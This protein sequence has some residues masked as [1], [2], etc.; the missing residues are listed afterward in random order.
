MRIRA[1]LLLVALGL[2]LTLM[3]C[4][5]EPEP[6]PEP[7]VSCG[8]QGCLGDPWTSSGGFGEVCQQERDCH[9]GLCGQ[10]TVTGQMFCTQRCDS[11][12]TCPRGAGCFSTGSGQEQVCGPPVTP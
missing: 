8:A 2:T 11:S 1:G 10:D 4:G 6:A 3:A 5:G 7:P 12:N 9:S